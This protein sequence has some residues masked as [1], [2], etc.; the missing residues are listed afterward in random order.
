MSAELRRDG[1]VLVDGEVIGTVHGEPRDWGFM[2]ADCRMPAKTPSTGW[3]SK[4]E[5]ADMCVRAH[6]ETPP[7]RTR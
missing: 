3:H 1:T 6:R 5:A 2:L 7:R 4:R